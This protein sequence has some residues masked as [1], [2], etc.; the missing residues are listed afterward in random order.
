VQ[1]VIANVAEAR[2]GEIKAAQVR[3]AQNHDVEFKVGPGETA[4]GF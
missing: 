4:R 1:E 3:L 2:G